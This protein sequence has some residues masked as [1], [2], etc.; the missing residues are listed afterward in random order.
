[1]ISS[2]EETQIHLIGLVPPDNVERIL[3][4][5]KRSLFRTF[6]LVSGLAL[7][8][9]L[10]LGYRVEPP[11]APRRDALPSFPPLATGGWTVADD[12]LFISLDPPVELSGLCAE[13][14]LPSAVREG[15]DAHPDAV[16]FEPIPLHSGLYVTRL[17]E[18]SSPKGWAAASDLQGK[19]PVASDVLEFLEAPPRLRWQA[20][21]VV[22]WLLR[23]GNAER[24]WDAI[25]AEELWAVRLRKKNGDEERS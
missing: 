23:C 2:M 21:G 8:P 3:T 16:H 6:S 19:P 5:I 18:P 12:T 14:G 24:W 15:S 10:P 9:I 22:C 7:R 17:L 11:A 1:M 13:L 4:D 20:S 25:V